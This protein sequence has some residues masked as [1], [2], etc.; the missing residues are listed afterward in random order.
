MS[1]KSP[2]TEERFLAISAKFA[3]QAS[4][5]D[6][7]TRSLEQAMTKIEDQGNPRNFGS[8][9]EKLFIGLSSLLMPAYLAIQG[10][11]LGSMHLYI[12]ACC[13]ALIW[14]PCFLGGVKLYSKLSDRKLGAAIT[15]LFK[16]L[17]GFLIPMFYISAESLRCIIASTPEDKIDDSGNIERCGNPSYPTWWVSAFLSVSWFLTY[18]IPPLLPSHRTLTW[19]D[20]MKLDM[21]MI[22]G[23]QFALFSTL[24]IEALVLYALIDEDGTQISDFLQGFINVMSLNSFILGFI[25]VY[26]HIIKPTLFRPTTRSHAASSVT[27]Q[28]AFHLPHAN[29]NTINAL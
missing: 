5:M 6:K 15:A 19:G 29:S 17:P 8:R 7:L 23:L 26:E 20:V 1:E 12:A 4:A 27:S 21:G 16:S 3:A 22:E 18:V 2:T 10:Y 24:S 11:A 28:D 14:L 25:V 9:N 13:W